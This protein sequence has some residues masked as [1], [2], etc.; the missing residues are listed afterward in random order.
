M[1]DIENSKSEAKQKE[2]HRLNRLAAEKDF[3]KILESKCEL[4]YKI[5]K[6][7]TNAVGWRLSFN[8][9]R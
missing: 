2:I 8:Q 4:N 9:F 1:I 3:A 6:I 7:L 5:S